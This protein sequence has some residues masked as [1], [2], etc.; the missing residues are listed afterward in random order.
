MFTTDVGERTEAAPLRTHHQR[1]RQIADL[2]SDRAQL[3]VIAMS[4]VWFG[5]MYLHVWRRHDR[6]G[7]FDHDLGFHDHYVW[8]LA[9]GKGF[10]DILG[11]H[12]FGLVPGRRR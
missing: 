8:L 7:T 10:S 9:R 12:A 4:T 11:L 1:A 5:L 2:A 6:F 3:F